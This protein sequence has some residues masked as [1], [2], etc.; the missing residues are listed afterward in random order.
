[1]TLLK[2]SNGGVPCNRFGNEEL[3]MSKSNGWETWSKGALS[4][5]Q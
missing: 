3:K 4:I 5:L 1:M 2:T